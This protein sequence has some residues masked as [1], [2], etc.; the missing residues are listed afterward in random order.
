MKLGI[1]MLFLLFWTS[2]AIGQKK[3][4]KSENSLQIDSLK[5]VDDLYREDQ[6]YAS[7]TY[8]LLGNKPNDV[9]QSGFST[10]YHFGFIRDMPLNKR[11]NVAI[12]IGLG[13]SSNSYNNT[14]LIS[15]AGAGY[16]YTVL[17]E[18]GDI[19]YDKNKFTNYLIELPVELRWRTSTA[20]E[21]DFWRIYAGFKLGYIAYNSSK[22]K[23]SL[24]NIR[25]SQ[26]DDIRRFQYGLTFSVGYSNISFHIYYALS[27]MF[28]ADAK[29]S[30]TNQNVDMNA[31]KIGL[32]F[33]IL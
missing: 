12:G 30:T 1:V 5:V 27:N 7:I 16:N 4:K 6:F 32:M 15:E 23:S 3:S 17:E 10:G 29:V 21:Y 26:I 22:F 25:L 19:D 8:N 20:T 13:L 11:R 2:H 28:N 33:Y 18:D 24:G 14:L 31:I 9:E